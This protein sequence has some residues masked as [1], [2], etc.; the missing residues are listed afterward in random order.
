MI[1]SN[2]K[3]LRAEKK[4]SQQQLADVL[5][6]GRSTLAEY[7]RSNTEPNI[8]NLLKISKHFAITVDQLLQ[9]NL[10]HQDLE[11]ERTDD[12]RVLAITMDATSGRH[13]IELVDTKAEAGY[14][15]SHQ[16]P[17]YIRELPKI[18]FPNMPSGTFRGFEINGDSM[19]PMESG[20]I[21]ICRHVE[22]LQLVKPG[23]TYVIASKRDGL[24]Y[25]RVFVDPSNQVLSLQSDNTMYL[26]YE[27]PFDE[28]SEIWQ[29]YAHL[30]FSD[31][32]VAHENATEDRLL[33]IQLKVTQIHKQILVN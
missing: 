21:V 31:Q 15:D 2:L 12:L 17:E 28:I 13:N 33:D 4:I 1:G 24:V 3:F 29:Y 26:P 6:I 14:L 8:D 20:S 32:K 16:N 18:Y 22:R 5:G 10:R 23:R 9:S 25:K 27:L 11:I 30:S 19:L 7:E